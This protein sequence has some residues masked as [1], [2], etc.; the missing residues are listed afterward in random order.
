[1]SS[2]DT[3]SEPSGRHA[4]SEEVS[5]EVYLLACGHGDT[6]LLRLPDDRWVLIDC[7][8]HN[9]RTRQRFFDFVRTK[10]INR[11]EFIFQTHPDFDHFCG[12]VEVLNHFTRN[13]RSVGYW[14]DGGLD[15]HQ[16]RDLIWSEELSER[17][18]TRLHDRLDELSDDGLIQTVSVNDWTRSIS[19]SGYANSALGCA[20]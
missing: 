17:E 19:P 13:G 20:R 5:V 6:I 4:N 12:M 7:H 3:A 1:M 14:C 8:L 16:V 9:R 15:A 18:Y 11:L 10:K 2:E